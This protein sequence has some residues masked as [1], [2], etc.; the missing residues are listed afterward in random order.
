MLTPTVLSAD[1]FAAYQSTSQGHVS[2]SSACSAPPLISRNTQ[3]WGLAPFASSKPRNLQLVYHYRQHEWFIFTSAESDTQKCKRECTSHTNET[4]TWENWMWNNL[5]QFLY[6]VLT[7]FQRSGIGI[8]R[9]EV[10]LVHPKWKLTIS[11]R[12]RV[13]ISYNIIY[14]IFSQEQ[15]KVLKGIRI[16]K[17]MHCISAM[18]QFPSRR[19]SCWIFDKVSVPLCRITS[20][21]MMAL[22]Q[23]QW[24][25]SSTESRAEGS[26]GYLMLGL[27]LPLFT[28]TNTDYSATYKYHGQ[29]AQFFQCKK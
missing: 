15:M 28:E 20:V 19:L 13:F 18:L 3:Q 29:H 17:S 6:S 1:N 5:A 23:T 22:H 26:T 12:I 8:R 4:K 27:P 10:V 16:C 9:E 24:S 25:S 2:T 7:D 21:D 14:W 11:V